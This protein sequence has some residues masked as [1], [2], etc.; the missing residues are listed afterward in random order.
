MGVTK[1]LMAS[2]DTLFNFEDT[3]GDRDD[4]FSPRNQANSGNSTLSANTPQP[5]NCKTPT[6]EM[7]LNAIDNKIHQA[8]EQQTSTTIDARPTLIPF[9]FDNTEQA[10]QLTDLLSPE[11]PKTISEEINTIEQLS[12]DLSATVD[13]TTNTLD[14]LKTCISV[15]L[16]DDGDKSE[17]AKSDIDAVAEV[18]HTESPTNET[19]TEPN[20]PSEYNHKDSTTHNNINDNEESTN[21]LNTQSNAE[22]SQN[23]LESDDF[24]NNIESPESTDS[25]KENEN[26][27]FS[28][29][30]K[31]YVKKP[32]GKYDDIDDKQKDDL[33]L[34]KIDKYDAKVSDNDAYHANNVSTAKFSSINLKIENGYNLRVH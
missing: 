12:S 13:A 21:D 1:V 32:T 11:Q 2:N 5:I 14:D 23:M 16:I 27:N 33:L 28:F 6:N 19:N 8:F 17:S 7:Y 9:N 10:S 29:D 18:Q 30:L 26:P 24:C 34:E 4:M 15:H 3:L 31:D 22:K 25:T 20:S